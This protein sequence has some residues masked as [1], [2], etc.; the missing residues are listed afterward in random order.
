ML[1]YEIEKNVGETL[2]TFEGEV[3]ETS[4]FSELADLS[5]RV[6]FDLKGIE[7]FNSEGIRRWVKFIMGLHMVD[8]LVMVRCSV[9]VVAQL[10]LVRGLKGT[11]RIESFYIPYTCVE[12]GEEELHLH[13]AEEIDDPDNPPVPES[14]P[15]RT[16]ELDDL[17]ERYFS[18]LRDFVEPR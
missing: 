16:L 14:A 4:D 7:R 8:E 12:T 10:N 17:A 13:L 9:A 2:V 5:G 15:G 1:R 18:F 3:D 6:T 11:F